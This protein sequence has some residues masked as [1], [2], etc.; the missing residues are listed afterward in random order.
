MSVLGWFSVSLISL[1]LTVINHLSTN[2]YKGTFRL[3]KPTLYPT[4]LRALLLRL[5]YRSLICILSTLKHPGRTKRA[6]GCL[7]DVYGRRSEKKVDGLSLGDALRCST[8]YV[9][10]GEMW[11]DHLGRVF[12]GWKPVPLYGNPQDGLA[13]TTCCVNISTVSVSTS[14]SA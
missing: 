5:Y 1:F 6:N 4:E 14:R 13:A 2:T 10:S 8:R 3:R 7:Y 12:T 9:Y 11:H